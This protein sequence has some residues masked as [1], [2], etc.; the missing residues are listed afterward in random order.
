MIGMTRSKLGAI[1]IGAL[2][3][4]CA[5]LIIYTSRN[6]VSDPLPVVADPTGSQRQQ[7]KGDRLPGTSEFE[8]RNTVQSG[9][10]NRYVGISKEDLAL[11][12]VA[13]RDPRLIA[14]YI[15]SSYPKERQEKALA[16]IIG[17]LAREDIGVLA[18]L[19]PKLAAISDRRLTFAIAADVWIHKDLKKLLEVARNFPEG[20]SRTELYN[21]IA[22]RLISSGMHQQCRDLLEEMPLSS[23]RLTSISEL[24]KHWARTD[25]LDV[26]KWGRTL[27]SSEERAAA[28][29][30][31]MRALIEK[32]DVQKLNFLFTQATPA[33]QEKIALQIGR[34]S[35]ANSALAAD[36][37]TQA[38]IK[39][40]T[41]IGAIS[42]A[43]DAELS[44][45]SKQIREIKSES[46]R[47]RGYDSYITRL[48]TKNPVA[49]AEWV[50]SSPADMRT[51]AFAVLASRWYG[52][53]TEGLNKWVGSLKPGPDKDAALGAWAGALSR[54]DP[55]GARKVLAEMQNSSLRDATRRSLRLNK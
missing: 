3:I 7:N 12:E 52:V 26:I 4:G 11:L 31:V 35:G 37:T 45:L 49:A 38:N 24:A 34:L 36:P 32:K 30:A 33:M 6:S 48:F 22:E 46:N 54:V 50:Q 44:Q 41:L 20:L 21:Q 40:I 8:D 1:A 27:P 18:T 15:K 9:E 55:D 23:L 29:D 39:E 13:R 17:E 2:A 19:G 43:E 14:E 10:G 53:D 47:N 16:W 5:S 42:T 51:V 28:E 25:Y